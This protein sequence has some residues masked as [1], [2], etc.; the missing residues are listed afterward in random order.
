[1]PMGVGLR[2]P[3]SLTSAT[4]RGCWSCYQSSPPSSSPSSRGAGSHRRPGRRREPIGSPMTV[5]SLTGPRPLCR[6][7]ASPSTA[8][9]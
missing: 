9:P 4:D 8:C 1:M 5:R 3:D 6:S 7:S 2:L